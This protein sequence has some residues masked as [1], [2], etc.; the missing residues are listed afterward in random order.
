MNIENYVQSIDAIT[1]FII[2]IWPVGFK[3]IKNIH[4]LY[5]QKEAVKKSIES[6]MKYINEWSEEIYFK[7]MTGGK[8]LENVYIHWMC[9]YT[10]FQIGQM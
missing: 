10:P 7:G 4:S 2:K 3:V 8:N 5:N 6:Y 1:S 9:I